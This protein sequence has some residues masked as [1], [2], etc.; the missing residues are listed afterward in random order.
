[1][2]A[3]PVQNASDKL[4][5]RSL[6]LVQLINRIVKAGDRQALEEFLNR[7]LFRY[8]GGR[9]LV[10]TDYLNI[11]RQVAEKMLSPAR[12]AFEIA[13][14]AYG[15]T[16]SK[17]IYLPHSSTLTPKNCSKGHKKMKRIG[18]DSRLYFN[19]FI[20]YIDRSFKK[21]PPKDQFEEE[22]RAARAMQ[23]LVNR[24]FYYSLL[25]AK[26]SIDP[27]WTRYNWN[28]NGSTIRVWL[29]IAIEGN[30]RRSWLERNIKN[31]DPGRTG[32]R[33]RVQATINQMLVREQIVP[34]NEAVR[35]PDDAEYPIWEE[36]GIS[37]KDSLANAVAEE[38]AMNIKQQRR[39]IRALGKRKLKKLILQIFESISH[40]DYKDVVIAKSFSLS[41][42]T[43]SRFAGSRWPNTDSPVPDLWRNT[44]QVLIECPVFRQVAK[45]TGFWDE[46]ITT[47]DRS[48]FHKKKRKTDV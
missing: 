32:E 35:I 43:F 25:E 13:D 14:K 30:E 21:K 18:S 24:H 4:F 41:K 26:R 44:A 27:F 46:V 39:T 19:A 11:R 9:L 36:P 22:T 15:L 2:V 47:V 37:F 38:K 8:N 20:K 40:D 12:N 1:M 6:S 7:T 5:C 45:D 23:G 29:P 34:I 3:K 31:P 42:A 17:F 48:A 33:D 10:L 28:I 16:L